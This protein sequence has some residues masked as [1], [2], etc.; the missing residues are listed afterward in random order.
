[1]PDSPLPLVRA[2]TLEDADQ[3]WPLA[4]AFATSFTPERAAF[5]ATWQRLL[6]DPDA[7]VAVAQVPGQPAR[8]TLADVLKV[9]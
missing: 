3:V 6:G 4:R 7:L 9:H 5:D 1:V 8:S 2:A